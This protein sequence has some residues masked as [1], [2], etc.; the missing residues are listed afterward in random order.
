M[1]RGA[2]VVP[3]DGSRSAVEPIRAV[4]RSRI[5]HRVWQASSLELY[6]F[7]TDPQLVRQA[8]AGGATGV[9]VDWEHLG[10]NER[11]RGFDT[12]VNQNSRE[13]LARVRAATDAPVICRINPVHTGTREEVQRAIALG[14]DEVLIPMVRSVAEVETVLEAVDGVVGVGI[15][16][17]T[18]DAVRNSE[19]LASLPLSR[20]YI[21]LHDLAI[22]RRCTNPFH[23]L[24]D[25]TIDAVRP[26]FRCP[27]GVAGLTLPGHGFPIPSELILHA[28]LRLECDFTFLRRS[29]LRDVRGRDVTSCVAHLRGHVERTSRLPAEEHARAFPAFANAVLRADGWFRIRNTGG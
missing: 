12:Q 22:D 5:A 17:E 10:K 15:M 19:R 6:L 20:V 8:V 11:Q 4:S 7:S 9:V 28:L 18:T 21:G 1:P 13:D 2:V 26:L 16:V 29:F 3:P 24:I 14:A 23:A 25:G 27:F